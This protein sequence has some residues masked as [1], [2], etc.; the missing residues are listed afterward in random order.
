MPFTTLSLRNNSNNSY[1]NASYNFNETILL[2]QLQH[3]SPPS[4]SPTA[5]PFY[6][7][8]KLSSP[9]DSFILFQINF[10]DAAVD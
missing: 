4:T 1:Q 2:Q 10:N 9:P 7:S 8:S 3:S 6:S 5:S